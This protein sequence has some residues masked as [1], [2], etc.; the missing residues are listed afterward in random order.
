MTGILLRHWRP[1]STL[2]LLQMGCALLVSLQP[3]YY[4]QIVSLAIEAPSAALLER[5]LP[6]IGL[7]AA[8]YAG[9]ALLMALGGRIGST[10]SSR[11]LNQFQSEFF[12]KTIHLPLQTFKGES[13]GSFFTRFNHDVG[14]TQQFLAGFVPT[15]VREGI[16]ALAVTV[17]LLVYGPPLLTGVALGIVLAMAMAVAALNRVMERYAVRQRRSW[18]EI[19][20][21]F[22]ETVKGIDTLKLF[23]GEH[24]MLATFKRQTARYQA[25]S[26]RAGTIVSVFSPGVDFISKMGGLLLVFLAYIQISRG[27]I[28]IDPFLLFFFYVTLLQTAVFNLVAMLSNIQVE[29]TGLRNLVGF[30]EGFPENDAPVSQE[31]APDPPA[32]LTDA[33]PIALKNLHFGYPGKNA[34]YRGGLPRDPRPGRDRHHRPQRQWQIHPDQ[35]FAALLHPPAGRNPYRP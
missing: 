17:I 19:N 13:T 25:L 3:R 7:L 29:L 8:L 6:I 18:T 26:I 10:F 5:G 32:R 28:Q 11:I 35:P 31:T 22:D 16:T 15:A 20:K 1:L 33:V 4:Q 9:A 14:Q 21:L 24:R 2:V 27:K 30:F 12:E 34:L 23:A